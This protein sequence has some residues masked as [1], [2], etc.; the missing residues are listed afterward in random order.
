[1]GHCRAVFLTFGAC[2]TERMDV[3]RGWS[4]RAINSALCGL[5]C[6]RLPLVPCWR[7]LIEQGLTSWPASE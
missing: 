1:M 7:S 2:S 5:V 4:E 3:A 6:R